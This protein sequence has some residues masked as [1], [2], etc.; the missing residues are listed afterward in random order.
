MG[1]DRPDLGCAGL[2]PGWRWDSTVG[3]RTG[4]VPARRTGRKS[5]LRAAAPVGPGLVAFRPAGPGG[6]DAERGRD[7]RHPSVVYRGCAIP[8]AWRIGCATQRGAWMDDSGT[9]AGTRV[10]LVCAGE[11]ATDTCSGGKN[12]TFCGYFPPEPSFPVPSRKSRGGGGSRRMRI[13]VSWYA[14]RFWIELGFKAVSL[15]ARTRRRGRPLTTPGRHGNLRLRRVHG[16]SVSFVL[17]LAGTQAHSS[18]F[19]RR[20]PRTR[21]HGGVWTKRLFRLVL[22]SSDFRRDPVD[23]LGSLPTIAARP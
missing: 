6:G 4:P 17:V 1:V 2:R 15:G 14:L 20:D 13:G 18:D 23:G 19:R 3:Q 8:V 16:Q 12:V 5:L 22:H 9:A 7:H 21:C 10:K 11:R